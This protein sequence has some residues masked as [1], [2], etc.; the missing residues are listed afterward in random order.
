MRKIT[1]H[2]M[3]SKGMTVLLDDGSSWVY[4]SRKPV[5]IIL[6]EPNLVGYG[7][8]EPRYCAGSESIK[9]DLVEIIK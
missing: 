2:W 5:G 8:E 4:Q 6:T 1:K 3:N 9:N 7:W